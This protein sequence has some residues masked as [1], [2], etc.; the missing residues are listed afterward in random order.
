L[1]AAEAFE[2]LA[3]RDEIAGLVG[4]RASDAAVSIAGW[5]WANRRRLDGPLTAHPLASGT[6]THQE[7]N[8]RR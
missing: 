5:A 7:G 3:A 1:T 4:D 2:R 8:D 6:T